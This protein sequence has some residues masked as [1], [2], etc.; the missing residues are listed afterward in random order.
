M[1]E[2]ELELRLD[3]A[4]TK[5]EI[6]GEDAPAFIEKLIDEDATLALAMLSGRRVCPCK[7]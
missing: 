5:V 6:F 7:K 4:K 2:Q 3:E 1:T